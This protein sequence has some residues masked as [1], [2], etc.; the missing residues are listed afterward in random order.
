MSTVKSLVNYHDLFMEKRQYLTAVYTCIVI[1]FYFVESDL[2]NKNYSEY[3]EKF[4]DYVEKKL[5]PTLDEVI[6]DHSAKSL[7]PLEEECI[8]HMLFCQSKS[9]DFQGRKDEVDVS[10]YN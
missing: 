9:Q 1:I 6:S 2:G 10:L 4:S 8:Q 5:K 3:L 7:S